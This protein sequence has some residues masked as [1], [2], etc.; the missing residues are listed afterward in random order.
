M[1]EGHTYQT[2]VTVAINLEDAPSQSAVKDLLN[3]LQEPI[4]FG[5]HNGTPLYK[6]PLTYLRWIASDT[7]EAK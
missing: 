1:P 6:V 5:K 4:W 2:E 7:Y 3:K